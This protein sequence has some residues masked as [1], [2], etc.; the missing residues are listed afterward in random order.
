[1]LMFARKRVLKL[2]TYFTSKVPFLRGTTE[3]IYASIKRIENQPMVFF[4]KTD[5]PSVLNK[6]ILYVRDN[7]LTNW[8]QIV[9]IYQDEESIPHDLEHN[10]MFID[11]QYPKMCIDLV[12]V[13]GVFDPSTVRK[14]SE[15][16]QVPRNF[17]FI[18]CPSSHFPHNFSD[19][20]VRVI[21]H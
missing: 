12:L 20:Q 3:K 21:T 7:E 16:L 19:L 8:L 17:M 15:Q 6:G 9:H 2:T 1:M 10:V 11:K 4:T 14:I 13:K 18:A 5:D